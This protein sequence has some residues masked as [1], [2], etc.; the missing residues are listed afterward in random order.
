VQVGAGGGQLHVQGHAVVGRRFSGQGTQ[1]SGF[2]WI[3][4]VIRR[5]VLLAASFFFNSMKHWVLR[6]ADF[7]SVYVVTVSLSSYCVGVGRQ[8]GREDERLG[9]GHQQLPAAVAIGGSCLECCLFVLLLVY[10]F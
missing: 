4:F 7:V 2:L 3:C 1:L 5:A 10:Y 9:E 8:H 6:V